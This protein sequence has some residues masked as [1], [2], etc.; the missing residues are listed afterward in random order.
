MNLSLVQLLLGTLA[1]ALVVLLLV[2][3]LVR[4]EGRFRMLAENSGDVVCLHDSLGVCLYV[5]PSVTRVLGIKTPACPTQHIYADDKPH[6]ERLFLSARTSKEPVRCTF[7]VRTATGELIWLESLMRPLPEGGIIATSRDVTDR[8]QVEDLYRILADSLPKNSFVLYD[9]GLRVMLAAGPLVRLNESLLGKVEGRHLLEIF[10][11]LFDR[12]QLVAAEQHWSDALE[13]RSHTTEIPLRGSIYQLQHVPVFEDVEVIAGLMVATNVTDDRVRE[14]ALQDRTEELERSNRD[15]EQFADIASHELKTPLRHIS[16][17]ADILAEE[18]EGLLSEEADL[19]LENI[20]Q[21]V[22]EMQGVIEAL[23][24]YSRAKTSGNRVQS[25]DLGA[26]V[27]QVLT[28][29]STRI[30]TSGGRVDVEWATLPTVRGDPVLLKQLL[31]NLIW[32]AIKF[33]QPNP[34]VR[35]SGVRDLLDWV[36]TVEDNGP[37]VEPE[38]REYIFQ[39]F[40]RSRV[41]VEGS[42]IGLA[43]C[44]KIVGIH[45][46]KIWVEDGSGPPGRRGALFKFSIPARVRDEITQH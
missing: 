39:M 18:H 24:R 16:G 2:R 41:D 27:K 6:L 28:S 34:V 1:V 44:K 19:C 12:E 40:K 7:R 36:V 14:A 35:V 3:R 32:N 29:L 8:K 13:G 23:L 37:G 43:L 15:L 46:G 30:A 9:R 22:H 33:S 21:G 17:F 25:V 10:R 5:S 45:R 31:E 20:T 42:G 4:S 26:L 11:H 38:H